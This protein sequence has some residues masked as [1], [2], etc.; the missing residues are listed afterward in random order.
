M[1][2]LTVKLRQGRKARQPAPLRGGQGRSETDSADVLRRC[3]GRVRDAAAD[4]D[5]GTASFADVLELAHQ[6]QGPIL[7]VIALNSSN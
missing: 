4:S 2:E 5:Q 3:R 6:G 1:D 7:A